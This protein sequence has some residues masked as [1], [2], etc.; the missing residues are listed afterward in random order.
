[1]VAAVVTV[2]AMLLLVPLRCC[3][4]DGGAVVCAREYGGGRGYFCTVVRICCVCVLVMMVLKLKVVI[5][6]RW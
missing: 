6:L 3:G 1:M 5:F 4:C 2:C